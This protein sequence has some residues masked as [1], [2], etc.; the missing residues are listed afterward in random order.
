MESKISE[1]GNEIKGCLCLGE[2]GLIQ[3]LTGLNE[4][5]GRIS[6]H[7]KA[8]D[9]DIGIAASVCLSN[10]SVGNAEFF[11]EKVFNFVESANH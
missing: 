10:L 6:Q 3:D 8:Q 5:F 7:F 4:I 11:L 9:E 2:I 1:P